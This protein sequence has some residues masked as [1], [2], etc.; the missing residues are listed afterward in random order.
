[1]FIDPEKQG[2]CQEL[3]GMQT[4][5]KRNLGTLESTPVPSETLP[6]AGG[7]P[8]ASAGLSRLCVPSSQRSSQGEAVHG[9]HVGPRC[10]PLS[11]TS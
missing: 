4:L 1:M 6:L 5:E 7:L 9:S 3:G 11:S 10:F 2:M 8:R